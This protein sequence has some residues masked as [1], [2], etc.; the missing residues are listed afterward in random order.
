[1][2]F[3]RQ[4]YW[5]GLLFLPPGNLP[6]PGIECT[7]PALAGE[8]FTTKPPG[9]PCDN[10]YEVS[11]YN[12]PTRN[13][14]FSAL[15]LSCSNFLHLCFHMNMKSFLIPSMWLTGSST[16]SRVRC[17][18]RLPGSSF[19]SH[20]VEVA[21]VAFIILS[22]L[23]CLWRPRSLP[24]L[25]TYLGT[26][27]DVSQFLVPRSCWFW[28]AAGLAGARER[29]SGER[30]LSPVLWEAARTRLAVPLCCVLYW[31]QISTS[32]SPLIIRRSCFLSPQYLGCLPASPP[33]GKIHKLQNSQA[34][35][36][37]MGFAVIAGL[38]VQSHCLWLLPLC[39]G[40]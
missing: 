21:G 40:T 39:L 28:P 17:R 9:K 38:A 27:A 30:P 10:A 31:P 2:G 37:S 18:S 34:C 6:N 22:I 3:S 14:T 19:R 36:W 5:S 7:S 15:P 33:T 8:F 1:M 12:I 35:F 13:I 11:K 25:P 29:T 4:K 32:C 16:H 23:S 26:S 20:W 24:E